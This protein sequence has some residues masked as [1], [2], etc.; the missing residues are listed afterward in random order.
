MRTCG[1]LTAERGIGPVRLLRDR[2]FCCAEHLREYR[3]QFR[4]K[5]Y[6]LLAPE[7]PPAAIAGFLERP[8]SK[9]DLPIRAEIHALQKTV[10]GR[11]DLGL[12]LCV[13]G[14]SFGHAGWISLPAAAV[15]AGGA[16][17][18]ALAAAYPISATSLKPRPLEDGIQIS[19]LGMAGM[20]WI[21]V[22]PAEG[23]AQSAGGRAGH[24][25]RRRVVV[26]PATAE[27]TEL[28]RAN[29]GRTLRDG[30]A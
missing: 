21:P 1:V 13:S 24:A 9:R 19:G 4:Q 26:S 2:E 16:A 27:T 7:P 5:V 22:R 10:P 29:W 28:I 6:E 15:R 25:G 3:E 30:T 8:T 23:V 20:E 14:G 12:E 18:R 17:P 11:L